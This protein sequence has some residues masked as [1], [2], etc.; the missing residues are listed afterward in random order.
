M[1]VL[2]P[3]L[4]QGL[5][6]DVNDGVVITEVDRDGMAAQMGLSPGVVIAR[7][8]NKAIK[9]IKDLQTSLDEAR[10]TGQLLLLVRSSRGTRLL[11][12]PFD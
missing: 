5:E 11:N 9:T 10:S 1:A 7:V 8:G 4:A 3:E 6:M 2:T 12:L